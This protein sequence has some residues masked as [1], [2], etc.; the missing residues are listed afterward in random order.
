MVDKSSLP[1]KELEDIVKM[2][3][4]PI[5]DIT[6]F[7]VY[8]S[9]WRVPLEQSAFQST[10]DFKDWIAEKL[11]RVKMLYGFYM[12]RKRFEARTGLLGKLNPQWLRRSPKVS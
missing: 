11:P 1:Y 2:T 5:E 9:G 12:D 6:D 3:D 8:L 7:D 10:D 4:R